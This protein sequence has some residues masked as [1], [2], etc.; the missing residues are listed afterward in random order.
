MPIF[1]CAGGEKRW[2]KSGVFIS[3]KLLP[4][5]GP[6]AVQGGKQRRTHEGRRPT[7]PVPRGSGASGHAPSGQ[8]VSLCRS[9]TVACP[10]TCNWTHPIARG[11]LWTPIRRRV[12]RV[13]LNGVA[14]PVTATAL[15]NV[16]CCYLS[17]SDR[18]H[19]VTLTGVSGYHVSHCVV[20]QRLV[21]YP[22]DINRWWSGFDSSLLTL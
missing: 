20:L 14:R 2:R 7:R 11:A 15:S 13:R 4:D 1:H 6:D 17:C 16:H 18:T 12:Q 19:P 10:V 9:D 5:A 8:R 22:F 21:A 3:K